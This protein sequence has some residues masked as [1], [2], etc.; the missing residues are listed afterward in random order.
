MSRVQDQAL[1]GLMLCVFGDD[2]SKQIAVSHAF[3]PAYGRM[4]GVKGRPSQCIILADASRIQF[5]VTTG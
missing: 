1:E 2:R 5:R 4:A 3:Q